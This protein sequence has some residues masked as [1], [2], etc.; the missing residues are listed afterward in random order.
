MVC[1]KPK[2]AGPLMI[3]VPTEDTILHIPNPVSEEGSRPLNISKGQRVS[4]QG[5]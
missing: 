1:Y 2:A 4:S 3:R 5:F